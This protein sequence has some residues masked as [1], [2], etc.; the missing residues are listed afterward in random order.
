MD[1]DVHGQ[2]DDLVDQLPRTVPVQVLVD[3]DEVPSLHPALVVSHLL[4]KAEHKV[5]A[6]LIHK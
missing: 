6:F 4:F 3:L 1:E 2:R 5:P